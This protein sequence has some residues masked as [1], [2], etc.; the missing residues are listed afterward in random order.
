M[1]LPVHIQKYLPYRN[2]LT[3]GIYGHVTIVSCILDYL[4]ANKMTAQLGHLFL[5]KQN[6]FTLTIAC[7]YSS[8]ERLIGTII[9]AQLQGNNYIVFHPPN[10]AT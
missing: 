1:D 5:Y 3:M 7:L 10:F 6:K 2:T 8:I 9:N 4:R